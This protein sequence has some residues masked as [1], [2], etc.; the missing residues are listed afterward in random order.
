MAGLEKR[1]LFYSTTS[2][3]ILLEFFKQ[4]VAKF[5]RNYWIT[6]CGIDA[7]LYL[8]FQRRI[9]KLLVGM[10]VG[11]L[12]ISFSVNLFLAVD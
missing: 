12:V 9:M 5:D 11:T 8:L 7:Y 3:S 1:Q 2:P 4:V 10:A 6:H